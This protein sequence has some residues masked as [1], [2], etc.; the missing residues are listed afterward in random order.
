MSAGP[1]AYH[2]VSHRRKVSGRHKAMTVTIDFAEKGATEKQSGDNKVQLWKRFKSLQL[3]SC[4]NPGK[5]QRCYMEVAIVYS[6]NCKGLLTYQ[7]HVLML[8]L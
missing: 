1:V 2:F 3:A 5:S 6:F 7:F 8:I 4:L